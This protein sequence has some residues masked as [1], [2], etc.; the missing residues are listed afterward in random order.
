[1]QRELTPYTHIV[2]FASGSPSGAF[3]YSVYDDDGNIVNGLE[4]EIVTLGVG[5]VSARIDVPAAAN[6]VS[7]PIFETRTITWTYPT[8][9]GTV[10]GSHSYVIQK[11]IPFPA[12]PEGVRQL[13]GVTESEIPDENIDLMGAYLAFRRPMTDPDAS[14]APYVISGDE[15]SY[16]ITRAIE[17]MAALE[18]LPTLQIALAKRFDSGTNSYERWN[19]IEW[20]N[21]QAKLAGLVYEATILVDPLLELAINP[22]F[23]LSIRDDPLTGA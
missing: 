5:A 7:K 21:L 12:T 17:A 6:A 10:N 8:N 19:K 9:S 13:L 14:L 16:R 11:A 1:M 4:N 22:I 20:D 23:V 3:S 2:E 15:D 18:V